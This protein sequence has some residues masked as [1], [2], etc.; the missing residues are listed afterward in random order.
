MHQCPKC[1][2]SMIGDGYTTVL[3]CENADKS[4][5]EFCE[6]D[7]GPIYCDFVDE[8]ETADITKRT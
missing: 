8:K 3:H 7:A 6:P 5:Y 4:K 1:G 2:G